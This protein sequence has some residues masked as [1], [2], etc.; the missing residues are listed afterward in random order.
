MD[1]QDSWAYARV[2]D[3]LETDF[4]SQAEEAIRTNYDLDG[5]ATYLLSVLPEQTPCGALLNHDRV[6][7]GL[8]LAH[9]EY[10][11]GEDSWD[12]DWGLEG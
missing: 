11:Q 12:L 2:A 3:A 4:K 5:A 6:R 8:R 9:E 1:L 7:E 10:W